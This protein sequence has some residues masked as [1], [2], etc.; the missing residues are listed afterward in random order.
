MFQSTYVQKPVS[1]EIA[2]VR[3]KEGAKGPAQTL[4]V[5]FGE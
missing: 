5:K 2:I 3:I 1:A 4:L